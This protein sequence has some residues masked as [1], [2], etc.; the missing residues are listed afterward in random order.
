MKPFENQQATWQKSYKDKERKFHG[1]SAPVKQ[2]KT[3]SGFSKQQLK[4]FQAEN[5]CDR[6]QLEDEVKNAVVIKK[7]NACLGS[8]LK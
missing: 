8:A 7:R 1:N 6:K 5:S 4:N 3:E 2:P